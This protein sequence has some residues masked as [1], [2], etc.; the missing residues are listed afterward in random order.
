VLGALPETGT[1]NPFLEHLLEF[2]AT[3]IAAP[4]CAAS[5]ATRCDDGP[6]ATLAHRAWII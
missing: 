1:Q 2:S 5:K 6:M 3:A 4:I